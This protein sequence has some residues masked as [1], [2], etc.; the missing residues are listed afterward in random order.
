MRVYNDTF[1]TKKM[2]NIYIQSNGLNDFLIPFL[3]KLN[4]DKILK[5]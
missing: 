1:I 3:K 5:F 2:V 4:L